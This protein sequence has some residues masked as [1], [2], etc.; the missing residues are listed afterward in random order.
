[1]KSDSNVL[2]FNQISIVV[3]L[4]LA[5]ALNAPVLVG[6][7]AVVML[8]GTLEPRLALFKQFYSQVVRPRLSIAVAVSQDDPRPHNFAQGL[9]G[10][11]LL[12]SSLAFV[13][14]APVVG[15]VVAGLVVA[16]ALLNLTTGICVGCFLYFQ[17][18]MLP[19]RLQKL[20]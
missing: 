14:A 6:V 1:M 5:A 15:W 3:L 4:L 16:L 12:L 9:G 13:L 17:W 8:L 7:V 19:H 11:F 2:R 20:R 18:K 10:V